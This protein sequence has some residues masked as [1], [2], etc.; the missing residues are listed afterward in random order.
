M[1][2]II[3]V[4]KMPKPGETVMGENFSLVPGGKG[5]N[6]SYA[7]G[8]LGADVKMIGAVGQDEN[9]E[10][11]IN[12]L[13]SVNVGIDGIK[14]I[15]NENTGC[16]FINVDDRGENSIVVIGGANQK[17]SKE[18]IDNN[19]NLIDEASIIVMQL[20]IPINVVTYVAKIAKQKEKIVIIDPA[21]ARGD[22]P[23]ELFKNIDI[24]KPNETEI[25]ILS[26][27]VI[28]SEEDLNKAALLLINKGVKNVIITLGSKG[29][30]LVTKDGI[31]KFKALNVDVV[32]TTAAGDSFIAALTKKLVEKK[33][34]EEAIEYAHIISSIVVTKKGAQ[35]S[36][37]DI[38]EVDDYIKRNK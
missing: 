37:P 38:Y 32:D 11:L 33:S 16:A 4:N 36:I 27:Q 26:G 14:K 19:M 10:K 35:T 3:D 13:K 25:E 17:L 18:F 31:K 28:N 15:Q 5:A 7:M 21:P 24:I 29:S 20:E 6:Q 34:L 9:G 12:N 8:K 22:L 23:D 30:I 1:D 2:F